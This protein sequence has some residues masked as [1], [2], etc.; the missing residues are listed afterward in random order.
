VDFELD[1]SSFF[2]FDLSFLR[3]ILPDFVIKAFEVSSPPLPLGFVSTAFDESPIFLNRFYVLPLKFSEC[4]V[5]AML[6]V[7]WPS[8]W[9][10]S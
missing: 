2:L 10:F 3:R 8:P 5:V 4:L 1:F 6:A 7:T 9:L